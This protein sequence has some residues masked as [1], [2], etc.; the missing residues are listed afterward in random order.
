MNRALL[1]LLLFFLG[2]FATLQAEQAPSLEA[3]V[4]APAAEASAQLAEQSQKVKHSAFPLPLDDYAKGEEGLGLWDTLV[5]RVSE[6]PFN[7]VVTLIFLAAIVHTFIS[8]SFMRKAHHL[9]QQAGRATTRS[10][11]YHYLGEVE[12]IFGLWAIPFAIS[13]VYFYSWNDFKLYINK[14]TNFTEPIFVT[15]IMIVAASR[16]IY[17]LAEKIL[18]FVA[19]PFKSTPKAWWLSI[20]CIA[21]LLGSFITEPAAMT[22][23]AILLGKKFYALKPSARLSY[24]TLGLLFVNVSV[25]G[26]LTHFAA[27]PIVMVASKWDWDMFYMMQN[28]GWKA[29]LGILVANAVYLI[30]F[31]R[32]F[33]LLAIRQKQLA[34]NDD[35]FNDLRNEDTT[36]TPAWVSIVSVLFLAWTVYSAHYPPMLLG[37]FLF[38][39]GFA[40]GLPQYQSPF[41][42]RTPMLVGFFLA[43]LLLLG[44]VQGWWMQPVLQSLGAM[45]EGITMAM[46]GALTA[47]NDNAAVT[48][49]ASTVPNLSEDIRYAIVAGAVAGGGLTVIANAPNPA[50]QAILSRYFEGGSIKALQLLVWALIP[51][52]ILFACFYFL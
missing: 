29:I 5:Y 52:L 30:I 3:S 32:E 40:M 43:G 50:G 49:L 47:F 20:L 46:A 25:G 35:P 21:P 9:E 6:E 8:P 33:R 28:F 23:A 48:F 2:I 1:T 24:A 17:R 44:G 42:F 27:P 4:T 12:V 41:S 11:L 7:L 14:D 10:A 31:S 13:C 26:T 15:V 18:Y 38:F 34:A 22:L 39:M 19:S 45:G 37:G 51:T 36:G 16:P